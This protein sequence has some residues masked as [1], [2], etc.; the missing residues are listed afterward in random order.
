MDANLAFAKLGLRGCERAGDLHGL[1]WRQAAFCGRNLEVSHQQLLLRLLHAARSIEDIP[2]ELERPVVVDLE[3]AG[4]G[5]PDLHRPEAEPARR[6]QVEGVVHCSKR[7][8]DQ[9]SVNLH[10][11][12]CLGIVNQQLQLLVAPGPCK[13]LRLWALHGH[14]RHGSHLDGLLLARL[15]LRQLP[16]FQHH[17]VVDLQDLFDDLAP[18]LQVKA[19]RIFPVVGHLE[20]LLHHSSHSNIPEVQPLSIVGEGRHH[21]HREGLGVDRDVFSVLPLPEALGVG[22]LQAHP[23]LVRARRL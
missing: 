19:D 16:V 9:W 20:G 5:F 1:V 13:A 3:L 15:Q 2:L 23:E 7:Q 14:G 21:I 18:N 8:W 12:T 22:N 10:P 6:V 17:T 4:A 11:F